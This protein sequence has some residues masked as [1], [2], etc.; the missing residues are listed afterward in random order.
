MALQDLIGQAWPHS[1][2]DPRAVDDDRRRERSLWRHHPEPGPTGQRPPPRSSRLGDCQMPR[3][4]FLAF[5][6]GWGTILALL[7]GIVLAIRWMS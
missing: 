1:L 7:L 6:L 2:A 5:A 3:R 4:V